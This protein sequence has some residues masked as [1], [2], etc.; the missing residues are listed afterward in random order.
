MGD[1]RHFWT[2][3]AEA[4]TAEA[5]KLCLQ[6]VAL[7]FFWVCVMSPNQVCLKGVLISSKMKYFQ[8]AWPSGSAGIQELF[9]QH[10]ADGSSSAW[11]Y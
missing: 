2:V 10:G 5:G 4:F 9:P 8:V 3:F 7:H 11:T 1:V 6:C